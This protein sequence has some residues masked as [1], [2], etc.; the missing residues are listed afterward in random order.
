MPS[1]RRG[2]LPQLGREQEHSAGTARTAARTARGVFTGKRLASRSTVYSPELNTSHDSSQLAGV[3]VT[4]RG[5]MRLL[6]SYPVGSERAAMAE[7]ALCAA[8]KC[9]TKKVL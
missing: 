7:S 8:S 2:R 3:G 9:S 4:R 1:T 6:P 5:P